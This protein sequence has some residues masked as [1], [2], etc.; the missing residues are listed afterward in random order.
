MKS[1]VVVSYYWGT[2]QDK[3]NHLRKCC[4]KHNIPCHI[5]CIPRFNKV[6]YQLAINYKPQFI[7]SMLHKFAHK[8]AGVLYLDVDMVINK[9]PKLF[10]NSNNDDMMCFNWNFDPAVISNGCIDPFVLE[11]AGGLMFFANTPRSLNVL[12]LWSSTLQQKQYKLCA[13]DRVLAMVFRKHN[14]IHTTRVS[15]LPVEY[16]YIPQYFSHLKLDSVICH[17]EDLTSERDA[18]MKSSTINRIPTDYKVQFSVRNQIK[19]RML[20]HQDKRLNR[21]LIAHGFHMDILFK[22]PST[23]KSTL[24][25]KCNSPHM[26]LQL[27]K[28][29]NCTIRFGSITP[30]FDTECDIR[31]N[32]Y[33][34]NRRK[35]IHNSHAFL[36]MKPSNT[37]YTLVKHWCMSTDHSLNGFCN[38]FNSNANYVLQSIVSIA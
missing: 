34:K 33:N 15:W 9:F 7:T 18:V 37:T 32:M 11:T 6:N 8:Y 3:A 26:I 21:R 12:S 13:D 31:S 4:K 2:Y 23:K 25:R 14:L 16:F 29:S 30:A 5:V 19:Y 1:F 24:T 22:S 10:D 28:D 36:F 27:W 38:V 17:P 20:P 35:M